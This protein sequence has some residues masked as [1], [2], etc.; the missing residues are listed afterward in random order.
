MDASVIRELAEAVAVLRQSTALTDKE[1]KLATLTT[2]ATVM[3]IG[4]TLIRIEQQLGEINE[5]L[6]SQQT[7]GG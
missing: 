6:K 4:P 7:M 1:I 3:H 5:R 2:A